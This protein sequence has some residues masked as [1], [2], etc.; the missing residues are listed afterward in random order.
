MIGCDEFCTLH[1]AR[2]MV[3]E[4]ITNHESVAEFRQVTFTIRDS[5]HSLFTRHIRDSHLDC[6][7]THSATSRR[8]VPIGAQRTIHFL[9]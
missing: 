3:V 5:G 7:C 1:V 4:G 9:C 8:T 6:A 2:C